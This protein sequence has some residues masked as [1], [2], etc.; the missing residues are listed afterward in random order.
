MKSPGKFLLKPRYDAHPLFPVMMYT[1]NSNNDC[2]TPSTIDHQP[3]QKLPPK[4]Q[5]NL[6]E[7]I[8]TPNYISSR[9]EHKFPKTSYTDIDTIPPTELYAGQTSFNNIGKEPM[10]LHFIDPRSGERNEK[11]SPYQ[12]NFDKGI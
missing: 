7:E 10:T 11:V 3:L 12:G 6:C 9:L 1:A 8:F 5:I 2:K 4:R